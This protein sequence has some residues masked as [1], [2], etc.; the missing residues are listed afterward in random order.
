MMMII[1]VEESAYKALFGFGFCVAVRRVNYFRWG[2]KFYLLYYAWS[3]LAA[4][5]C[6]VDGIGGDAEGE[7]TG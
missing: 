5:E 1:I 3:V 6:E 4:K 7:L 2:C